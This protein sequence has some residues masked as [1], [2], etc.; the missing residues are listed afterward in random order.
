MKSAKHHQTSENHCFTHSLHLSP[1]P[2]SPL[3]QPSCALISPILVVFP[4]LSFKVRAS[5][6]TQYPIDI[7]RMLVCCG[8]ITLSDDRSVCR[9]PL[10]RFSLKSSSNIFFFTKSVAEMRCFAEK[11]GL[12]V[13][14]CACFSEKFRSLPLTCLQQVSNLQTTTAPLS[15]HQNLYSSCNFC[16]QE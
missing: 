2:P 15:S 10:N 13:C 1:P 4:S 8:G 9:P 6:H 5:A 11:K 3:L 12:C 16:A 14:T 7:P